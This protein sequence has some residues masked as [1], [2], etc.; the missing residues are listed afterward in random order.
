[1]NHASETQKTQLIFDLDAD[2]T[3][4][5]N[6]YDIPY[7]SDLRLDDRGRPNMTGYPISKYAFLIFGVKEISGDR[8]G[9]PTVS[10]AY[11]RFDGVLSSQDIDR[12]IPAELDSPVLLVDVDPNSPDR[13]K[14][15]PTVAH[16]L[17]ADSAYI[18]EHTLAVAPYPGIVL[19]PHRKYAYVVMKTLKDDRGELLGAPESLER[20]LS[21]GNPPNGVLG[22]EAHE[23]F[24]PLRSMLREFNIPPESVAAATVFTTG[25]PAGE[26]KALSDGVRAQYDLSIDNLVLDPKDGTSHERFC[27]LHATIEFPQF[28]QGTPPFDALIS[29]NS[30]GL[31]KINPNGILIEQRQETANVVI[32]IPKT[33]MPANGYPLIFYFHGSNGRST[34]VVDRGPIPKPGEMEL[35]GLGPAHIVAER[36]FAA[37]ASALPLNPERL[38]DGPDSAYQNFKNLAAYRDTFRQGTIEQGLLLDAIESLE[39]SPDIL[40][41]CSGP[42]LPLG[43]THFRFETEKIGVLGQSHGAQ[44]ANIFGAIEPKVVA[45]VPTGS[46]GFW[47]LYT[48]LEFKYLTEIMLVTKQRVR[49]LHPGL[50]L[51]QTSWEGAEPMAYMPHIAVR[52]LAGHPTR[53]IYNPVGLDDMD[54]PESIF[55]ALALATELQ[56]AGVGLWESMQTSLGVIGLDGIISYP[57]TNNLTSTTGRDYTGVVVQYEGDGIADPHTIFSQLDEVKYQYGCF[58]KAAIIDGNA[59]VSAP[60]PLGTSCP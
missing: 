57:V 37:V 48:E 34:Q 7:P 26:L 23:Q 32:T 55:D 8:T 45:V 58:F 51:L 47:S 30:E 38:P 33:P 1:M 42:S 54:N 52:P 41:D 5:E 2:A 59:T 9:F 49:Y 16:D 11:F 10:A 46:G 6:F 19:P 21:E 60:A 17:I 35:A 40:A 56:Q 13:G 53:S 44:Y 36:G 12:L 43:A 20:L 3:Q 39:I 14:L 24:A 22:Q 27:E 25:D 18:P 4:A 28:Q 29:L 15:Y 50:Q 31:F